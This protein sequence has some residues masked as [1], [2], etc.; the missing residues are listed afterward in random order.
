MLYSQKGFCFIFALELINEA[1]LHV[2][3][4]ATFLSWAFIWAICILKHRFPAKEPKQ[5]IKNKQGPKFQRNL[6][7]RKF[8]CYTSLSNTQPALYL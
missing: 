8:S 3:T 2:H 6:T 5:R 4:R 7:E 1:V